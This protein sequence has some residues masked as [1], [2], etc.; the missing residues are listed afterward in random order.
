MANDI[1]SYSHQSTLT[2]EKLYLE[3]HLGATEDERN[4]P[5]KVFIFLTLFFPEAPKACISDNLDDT[6]CY[7][8]LCTAI[9]T[10]CTEKHFNM[11]EH[12]GYQ[13]YTVARELILSPIKIH[14]KVE[15][16]NPPIEYL[17]GSAI[18]TYTD[19]NER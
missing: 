19:V 17:L 14:I 12:L 3:I 11:I 1:Y 13:I 15:K 4:I 16:C 18:F 2:L 5:Q 7:H 10:Y 8:K 6:I 9:Q